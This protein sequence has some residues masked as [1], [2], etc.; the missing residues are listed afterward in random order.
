MLISLVCI[1]KLPLAQPL[2]LSIGLYQRN[3]KCSCYTRVTRYI[4]SIAI[5][6][7]AQIVMLVLYILEIDIWTIDE[8]KDEKFANLITNNMGL[9]IYFGSQ[10]VALFWLWCFLK[11][12]IKQAFE[13]YTVID[14]L[15]GE[16][17]PP[18]SQENN[19]DNQEIQQLQ[20]EN[21]NQNQNENENENDVVDD[22]PMEEEPEMNV[23]DHHHQQ[24]IIRNGNHQLQ[25]AVIHHNYSN[26]TQL[27]QPT[28]PQLQLQ[29][30]PPQ[31][32]VV[33]S[34]SNEVLVH[35]KNMTEEQVL[36]I[37]AK[38]ANNYDAFDPDNY[39]NVD[40]NAASS[41]SHSNEDSHSDSNL[42]SG[43]VI[44]RDHRRDGTEIIHG[45][46]GNVMYNAKQHE[47]HK[48]VQEIEMQDYNP[49]VPSIS[50]QELPQSAPQYP[51]QPIP[52]ESIYSVQS[53]IKDDDA[54][55]EIAESPHYM[56]SYIPPQVP[57]IKATPSGEE[58]TYNDDVD[59][60]ETDPGDS[61]D[62]NQPAP[63]APK[64]PVPIIRNDSTD[65][66]EQQNQNQYN[67]QTPIQPPPVIATHNDADKNMS[68]MT[69]VEHGSYDDDDDEEEGGGG[70]EESSAAATEVRHYT[71]DE[72]ESDDD[73]DEPSNPNIIVKF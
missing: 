25:A 58:D 61:D 67:T 32:K 24:E 17:L 6:A 40:N 54:K 35:K 68:V 8:N 29:P 41:E 5:I 34:N 2:D 72:D 44:D 55:M 46:D 31:P 36:T 59:D 1:F 45:D 27:T 49:N 18:I 64:P 4:W 70:E 53:S 51:A 66:E 26:P 22:K 43:F 13:F 11:I 60:D 33:P 38:N 14:V 7:I 21:Q 39:K 23:T 16:Y 62:E 42:E 47:E 15:K 10:F 50:Q 73:D 63:P 57:I 19:Q 56:P 20:N 28:Q 71:D 12:S 37:F 65:D 52:A 30:Q 48:H 69:T 9:L 3:T